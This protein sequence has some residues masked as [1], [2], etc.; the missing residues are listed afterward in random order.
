MRR[1]K[2]TVVATNAVYLDPLSCSSTIGYKII[3]EKYSEGSEP[4]LNASIHLADCS[5]K[6]EWYFS[7]DESMLDKVNAAI[8]ILNEFKKKYATELKKVV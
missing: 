7:N 8:S 6:I 3:W 2:G 4:I 5:H 1:D